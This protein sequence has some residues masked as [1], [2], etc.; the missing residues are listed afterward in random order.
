MEAAT[1]N[2]QP[3][4]SQL[5]EEDIKRLFITPWI[6]KKWDEHP[7]RPCQIASTSTER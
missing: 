2:E 4:K 6:E 7:K 1:M 3:H 5:T